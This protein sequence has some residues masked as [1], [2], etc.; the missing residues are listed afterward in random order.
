MRPSQKWLLVGL[1]GLMTSGCGGGLL[2]GQRQL[3]DSEFWEPM[4]SPVAFGF[5]VDYEPPN[6]G[7]VG[8]EWG[9]HGSLDSETVMPGIDFQTIVSEFYVGARFWPQ[10]RDAPQ[11][12]PYL[13]L[14]VEHV[15]ARVEATYYSWSIEED[16]SSIGLY[17]RG[18][19]V[20]P[21]GEGAII[22]MDLRYVFATTIEMPSFAE[23][24]VDGLVYSFVIGWGY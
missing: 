18:G 20:F 1:V 2:L 24:D 9:M 5:W 15:M 16:D 17:V 14:G 13:G 11:M 12:R 3:A 8:F 22:G 6:N 4:E 21:V 19:L 10:G 7:P 23:T